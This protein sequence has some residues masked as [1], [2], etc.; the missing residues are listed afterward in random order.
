MSADAPKTSEAGSATSPAESVSTSRPAEAPK[1]PG[2]S[3]SLRAATKA[4]DA[5]LKAGYTEKVVPVVVLS[6]GM[7]LSPVSGLARSVCCGGL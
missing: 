4:A 5:A 3:H 2:A 7:L 1:E 6:M